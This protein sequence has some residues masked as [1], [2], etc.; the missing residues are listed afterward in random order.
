MA[1]GQGAGT[2]AALAVAQGH[3]DTRR[4]DPALLRETLRG[5]GAFV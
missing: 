5:Q 3:C 4:V 1:I 2:A